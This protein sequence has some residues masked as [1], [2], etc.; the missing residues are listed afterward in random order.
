MTHLCL[1]LLLVLYLSGVN[2]TA[3]GYVCFTN[4]LRYRLKVELKQCYSCP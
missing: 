1:T 3:S 4:F 2:C